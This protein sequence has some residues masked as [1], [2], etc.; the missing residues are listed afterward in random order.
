MM[1]EKNNAKGL[2]D[3]FK[4]HSEYLMDWNLFLK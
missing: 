1:I 3:V 4:E 2:I